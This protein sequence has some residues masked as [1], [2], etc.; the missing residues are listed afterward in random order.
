[1]A[2]GAMH[3]VKMFETTMQCQSFYIDGI[4]PNGN[5]FQQRMLGML[6][7][8]SLYRYV[9]PKEGLPTVMKTLNCDN[10]D[11]VPNGLNMQ[12]WGL[13]KALNLDPLPKIDLPDVE[14]PIVKDDMQIVPIGIKVDEERVMTA[15][16]VKQ[17]AL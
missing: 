14:M 15:T 16:G 10:P 17:E 4:A 3:K 1:M 11:R 12:A 7:P 8:I 2:T 13:R 9:F 6:E 5:K